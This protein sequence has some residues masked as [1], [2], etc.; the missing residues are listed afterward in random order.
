MATTRARNVHSH[1]YLPQHRSHSGTTRRRTC[2]ITASGVQAPHTA[3]RASSLRSRSARAGAVTL[4]PA[5]QPS[6]GGT[7][8]ALTEPG[9][10]AAAP[11][12]IADTEP[13]QPRRFSL[14]FALSFL[15]PGERCA[16]IDGVP[17]EPN[18][19]TPPPPSAPPPR[20][21]FFCPRDH[22]TA[23]LTMRSRPT[24]AE[25]TAR[26][27]PLPFQRHHPRAVTPKTVGLAPSVWDP[28]A[29]P[30][31]GSIGCSPKGSD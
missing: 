26:G 23:F 18:G 20:G 30:L 6:S 4:A 3:H 17:T 5:R 31:Q 24:A 9:P 21:L 12:R 16:R 27:F 15:P 28:L 19:R 14:A 10:H 8:A 22:S 29:R 13:E 2:D 25:G 7:P 11:G 1:A